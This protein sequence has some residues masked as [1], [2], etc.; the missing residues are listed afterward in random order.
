[1]AGRKKAT[2]G[3]KECSEG[4]SKGVNHGVSHAAGWHNLAHQ[5]EMGGGVATPQWPG[6]LQEK[7]KPVS[8]TVS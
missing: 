2:T 1:M 6:F 8:S 3:G 4:W 5:R 7:G